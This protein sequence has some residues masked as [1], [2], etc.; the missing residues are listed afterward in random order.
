[1]PAAPDIL[2][3]ATYDDY[4]LEFYHGAAAA[5]T[6]ADLVNDDYSSNNQRPYCLFVDKDGSSYGALNSYTV[7]DTEYVG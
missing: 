7:K 3:T 2:L 1:M 6:L 4:V 5:P